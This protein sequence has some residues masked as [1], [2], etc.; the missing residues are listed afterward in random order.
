MVVASVTRPAGAAVV[1]NVQLFAAYFPQWHATPL[2]DYWFGPNYTDWD[3]LCNNLRNEG[4]IDPRA[5][6]LP[7]RRVRRMRSCVV[8]C[9]VSYIRRGM[10]IVS[11]SREH[12]PRSMYSIHD[13]SAYT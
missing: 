10:G 7:P 5:G 6:G 9:V 8:C 4:E 12:P 2:N 13:S 1:P 3:L 11:L